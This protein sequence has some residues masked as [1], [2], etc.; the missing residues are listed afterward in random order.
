MDRPSLSGGTASPKPVAPGENVVFRV[1]ADGVAR[2]VFRSR[3]L[4]HALAWQG[5]QLLIGTGPDGQL[6]ELRDHGRESAPLLG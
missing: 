1:G 5:D 6:F 4:I 2:E 3:V